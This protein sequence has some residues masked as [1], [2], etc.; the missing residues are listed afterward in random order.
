[1]MTTE[2]GLT[3]LLKIG[4]Q[5]AVSILDGRVNGH[6]LGSAAEGRLSRQGRH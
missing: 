3:V 2:N 6:Q 1:M 5:P 4:H